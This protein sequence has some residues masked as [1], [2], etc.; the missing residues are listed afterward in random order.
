MIT[1]QNL[2]PDNHDQY[3]L[4]AYNIRSSLLQLKKEQK[5]KNEFIITNEENIN[6]L[7]LYDS[8]KER[9]TLRFDQGEALQ[10]SEGVGTY[11]VQRF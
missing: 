4:P 2:A 5:S 8:D 7:G 1:G 3:D 11:S 10:K 6:L 9:Y